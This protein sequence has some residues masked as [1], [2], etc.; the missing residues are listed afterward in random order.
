VARPFSFADTAS[1]VSP[2]FVKRSHLR[3]L[4]VAA[5]I[6]SAVFAAWSW[7]RPYAWSAD[8]GARCSVVGVQV[9]QDESFFWVDAHL[10]VAS[11]KTHDLIKPVRLITS[12]G[13]VLEPADTTLGGKPGGGTTDLWLKFWLE[14]AD[15]KGPLKLQIN[16]GK[17]VIR[18]GSGIP[19]LGNSNTK[20]FTTSAW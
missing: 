18:S 12:D 11:G 19:R 10:K 5:L 2:V 20:Y 17:L 14:S 7:M 13:R 3:L 16:D 9:K 1:L 6:V 4:L 15:M 8:P